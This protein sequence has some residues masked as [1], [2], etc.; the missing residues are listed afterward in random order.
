MRIFAPTPFRYSNV[1]YPY[2][3]QEV[4]NDTL[5]AAIV[6]AGFAYYDLPVQPQA[7]RLAPH[8][9]DHAALSVPRMLWQSGMPFVLPAGDGGA[10]GLNFTGTRGVFTLS[11]AILAGVSGMLGGCYLYLP[12]GAGGLGSAG[13]RWAQFTDD[14]N[15]EVFQETYVPGSGLPTWLSSPTQQP[16]LTAGRITQTISEITVASFTQTGGML[17]PNGIIRG[18][19]AQRA[20]SSAGAKAFRCRLGGITLNSNSATSTN[21]DL[22]FEFIRQNAGVQ[23]KQIGNR[24]ATGWLGSSFTTYSSDNSSVDTSVDQT[25]TFTM[26]LPANTDSAILIPRQYSVTYGA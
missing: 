21:N 19:L 16:S 3:Y 2:G 18:V 22:D 1:D 25:V 9:A 26:Q 14:T 23:T 20:N 17:G 12:A 10:N 11:A 15:G 6:S 24:S 7:I 13:W 4:P 8:L 5:A